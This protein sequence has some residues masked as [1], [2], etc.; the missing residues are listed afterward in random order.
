MEKAIIKNTQST[1]KR[2]GDTATRSVDHARVLMYWHIGKRIFEEEQYG[3]ERAVYRERLI[4]YILE[5]LLPDFGSAYS[6]RNLNHY[7]Q[8]YR[9]FPI[10]IAL[11]S[12]LSWTHY[13]TQAYSDECANRKRIFPTV[14]SINL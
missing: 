8:F 2:L 10:V 3:H 12:Q 14:N 1:I 13:R 6:I 4:P 9:A 11:R 5:Q 7:R